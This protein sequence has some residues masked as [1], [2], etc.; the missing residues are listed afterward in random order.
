VIVEEWEAKDLK[1]VVRCF[2][3]IQ[4]FKRCSGEKCG[5]IGVTLRASRGKIG[6]KKRLPEFYVADVFEFKISSMKIF[7]H[8]INTYRVVGMRVERILFCGPRC[9]PAV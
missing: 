7:I 8:S 6:Q 1:R 2:Q 3:W 9:S 4:C 5:N